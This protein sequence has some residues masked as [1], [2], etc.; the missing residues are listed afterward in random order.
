LPL[1]GN[2]IDLST[3]LDKLQYIPDCPFVLRGVTFGSFTLISPKKRVSVRCPAHLPVS[4]IAELSA[5]CTAEEL[6]TLAFAVADKLVQ[7]TEQIPVSDVFVFVPGERQT[8]SVF[9]LQGVLPVNC[10]VEASIGALAQALAQQP[11][12][13]NA[14]KLVAVCDDKELPESSLVVPAY[15]FDPSRILHFFAVR[16]YEVKEA[17]GAFTTPINLL[18]S[19]TVDRAHGVLAATLNSSL[20]IVANGQEVALNERLHTIAPDW[21]LTVRVQFPPFQ[22]VLPNGAKE[23]RSLD[24]LR[25]FQ[26]LIAEFSSIPNVR[27]LNSTAEI[28]LSAPLHTALGNGPIFVCIACKFAHRY[29]DETRIKA[30]RPTVKLSESVE[31]LTG[32]N[33]REFVISCGSNTFSGEE[34]IA[35]VSV[36]DQAI[37]LTRQF[38]LRFIFE[39]NEEPFQKVFEESCNFGQL[40][41]FVASNHPGFEIAL[42]PNYPA[43]VEIYSVLPFNEPILIRRSQK[44]RPQCPDVFFPMST[45]TPA[46]HRSSHPYTFRYGDTEDRRTIPIGDSETV[47]EVCKAVVPDRRHSVVLFIGPSPLPLDEIFSSIAPLGSEVRVEVQRLN[48]TVK[49]EDRTVQIRLDDSATV[50]DLKNPA[51]AA[52]FHDR[53]VSPE[54]LSFVLM[55][56][57]VEKR[58]KSSEE[59][60]MRLIDFHAHDLIVLA[61]LKNPSYH[62][63]VVGERTRQKRFPDSATVET[64]YEDWEKRLKRPVILRV[65][66]SVLPRSTARLASFGLSGQVISVEI[67]TDQENA[68][69]QIKLPGHG[70]TTFKLRLGD[71]TKKVL[72]QLT[73]DNAERTSVSFD[74]KGNPV[75]IAKIRLA[76]RGR[77]LEFEL[78]LWPLASELLEVVLLGQKSYR[79]AIGTEILDQ[80][81]PPE[82]TVEEVE[83]RLSNAFARQLEI[84]DDDVFVVNGMR[85]KALAS[86][87]SQAG[88]HIIGVREALRTLYLFEKG[89]GSRR[90]LRF[91]EPALVREAKALLIPGARLTEIRLSQRGI[92]LTDDTRLSS[93]DTKELIR[94]EY[95]QI[96]TVQC[97]DEDGR[98]ITVRIADGIAEAKK[99]IGGDRDFELEV[100]GSPIS[101]LKPYKRA[102]IKIAYR[103]H[104]YEFNDN[105]TTTKRALLPHTKFGDIRSDFGVDSTFVVGHEIKQPYEELASVAP[106]ATIRVIRNTS[107]TIADLVKE[108]PGKRWV[109]RDRDTV[110]PGA[111]SV[112]T[113]IHLTKTPTEESPPRE[114]TLRIPFS[115]LRPNARIGPR[116][117]FFDFETTVADVREIVA[118]VT[119]L[120]FPPYGLFVGGNCL[121]DDEFVFDVAEREIDV[122]I[123]RSGDQLRVIDLHNNEDIFVPRLTTVA[124]IKASL[125]PR[126]GGKAIELICHGRVLI[127]TQSVH[128]NRLT[129]D[130]CIYVYVPP[131]E[132]EGFGD[133]P[134]IPTTFD[135]VF[136]RSPVTLPYMTPRTVAQVKGDLAKKLA[137]PAAELSIIDGSQMICLEDTDDLAQLV[138]PGRQFTIALVDNS[139]ELT[140]D[141][142]KMIQKNMPGKDIN[143]AKLLFWQCAGHSV[144]FPKTCKKRGFI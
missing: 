125:A 45:P 105:G 21:V 63:Q 44:Q 66:T 74:R 98:A 18:E 113:T 84:V 138:K 37:V 6:P 56:G 29:W 141:Q 100:L 62:F 92:E 76:A 140:E 118:D 119:R 88:Q 39:T 67:A 57:N 60:T 134:I 32:K 103:T 12:F 25:T 27:F 96:E 116:T 1:C 11:A 49:F 135:F 48:Y 94:L 124:E 130:S 4:Q 9:T 30:F 73:Y 75:D 136:S 77:D 31:N 131:P 46:L 79:F 33:A 72:A 58:I 34:P 38:P 71:T 85:F 8:P 83:W 142:K 10:P 114:F 108:D 55:R 70:L 16:K 35:T 23:T 5:I 19:L 93:A 47:A 123:C 139:H 24:A 13:A 68:N 115:P 41:T 112:A 132:P 137:K 61:C 117:F 99:Q 107:K 7:P 89:D 101:I 102:P 17:S 28:E 121:N 26:S 129:C 109:F 78:P 80:A 69:V 91:G 87:L 120:T 126:Y 64:V 82:A 53:V 3:A 42:S 143:E 90:F 127:D 52:L 81:V 15:R 106:G 51:I 86:A 20:V 59:S 65:G 144:V 43:N 40:A 104:Y 2:P 97:L 14:V 111:V 110:L 36:N 54:S 50:T 133:M 95:T 122:R 128:D 22:F